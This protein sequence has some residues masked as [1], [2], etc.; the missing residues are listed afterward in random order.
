MLQWCTSTWSFVAAWCTAYSIV[1][2]TCRG[3]NSRTRQLLL[4]LRSYRR[5][6]RCVCVSQGA[7]SGRKDAYNTVESRARVQYLYTALERVTCLYRYTA[8]GATHSQ[9]SHTEHAT[10]TNSTVSRPPP[11]G[12]GCLHTTVQ[13]RPNISHACTLS[14]DSPC[15]AHSNGGPNSLVQRSSRSDQRGSRAST[16]AAG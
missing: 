4:L 7:H 6:N 5:S 10:C 8:N 15:R 14:I 11:R 1:L 16:C 3:A 12:C 9:S 13:P 2:R